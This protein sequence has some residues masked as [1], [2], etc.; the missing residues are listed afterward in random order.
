MERPINTVRPAHVTKRKRGRPRKEGPKAKK[1]AGIIYDEN[2]ELGDVPN[3][4]LTQR[5]QVPD[6]D[7]IPV[8]IQNGDVPNQVATEV[9]VI[10]NRGGGDGLDSDAGNAQTDVLNLIIEKQM[11]LSFLKPFMPVQHES[12]IN[13]CIEMINFVN[14]QM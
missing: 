7:D 8:A 3:P 11:I 1:A 6:R 14:T 12:N 2:I 13:V 10:E 9:P 5:K 4:V